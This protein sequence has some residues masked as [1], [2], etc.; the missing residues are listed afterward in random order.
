MLS[1][2]AGGCLCGSASPD[3]L[4][5]AHNTLGLQDF[6]ISI[7]AIH[8]LST[9]D[10][11]CLSVQRLIRTLHLRRAGAHSR[12]LIYVWAYE[13]GEN[14]KRKMGALGGDDGAANSQDVLVPWVLQPPQ[15]P[16]QAR[17][18][19]GKGKQQAPSV[20]QSDSP[21]ETMPPPVAAPQVFHRYYHLF[22]KGE[23]EQLITEAAEREGFG[24]VDQASSDSLQASGRWL[25][26]VQSGY[27]RDNWWL[28]GEVG[29]A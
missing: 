16:Q 9:P 15:Q 12:F 5:R 24:V 4:V 27:E 29:L 6:A 7:A 8:H 17:Q 3:L 18:K 25:R 11:R 22:V 23:L 20:G 19:K 10:R 13:Q 2:L 21:E 28:E 14:S 26:I 1:G